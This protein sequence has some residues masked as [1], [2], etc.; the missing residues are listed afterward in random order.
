MKVSP[1]SRPPL[2]LII[3]STTTYPHLDVV[4]HPSTEVSQPLPAHWELQ[5]WRD[6]ET[7]LRS[8]HSQHISKHNLTIWTE[9]DCRSHYRIQTWQGKQTLTQYAK[10][11][12]E[13]IYDDEQVMIE[14]PE[15]RPEVKKLRDEF[16]SLL[17]KVD[18]KTARFLNLEKARCS[19]SSRTSITKT[20]RCILPSRKSANSL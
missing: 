11:K 18:L 10:T 5:V 17:P 13:E 8:H 19:T 1:S 6:Q 14:M 15:E 4:A 16:I 12:I 20:K 2:L 3:C 7:P 9:N